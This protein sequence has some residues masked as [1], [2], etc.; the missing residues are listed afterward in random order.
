MIDNINIHSNLREWQNKIGY[1][2]QNVFILDDTLKN[3]IVFGKNDDEINFELLE[4]AITQSQLS[5]FVSSLADGIETNVGERGAKISGGQMQRI[6]IDRALYSNPSFL[7][8]DESTNDL[9]L[10]TE[11]QIMNVIHELREKNKFNSVSSPFN[12]RKLRYCAEIS[13]RK[14]TKSIIHFM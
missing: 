6:A 11:S 2:S 1:V 14:T 8:F 9:D 12:N 10:E 3:N 13:G 7:I 4:K 5:D